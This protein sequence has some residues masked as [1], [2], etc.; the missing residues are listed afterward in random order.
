MAR[1]TRTPT[2]G[3]GFRRRG[4]RGGTTSTPLDDSGRSRYKGVGPLVLEYHAVS[5]T[6]DSDLAVTPAQLRRHL[7]YLLERGYSG[8]TF[9]QAAT[10]AST[11]RL[12]AVTFDDAH[13]SVLELAYPIL[14]S[15]GVPGT[16]FVV[17]DYA[18]DGRLLRWARSREWREAAYDPELRGM[19]WSHLRQLADAGWEVGSHTK[20]H[21]R[22]T[23]LADDDLEREL[24]E[25]REACERALRRRC[26]SLAYPFGN[27]DARVVRMTAQAGYTVAA[28]E[29]PAPPALLMW[30][31]VGI[32]R[33]DSMLRFRLKVSPT[34][35]RIWTALVR[36][37]GHATHGAIRITPETRFAEMLARR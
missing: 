37:R 23:Q 10:G 21:P 26:S 13:L 27:T 12:V 15:L 32:Y 1:I 31:R 18:D 28:I 24:R 29:G 7:E 20:T 6:W 3:N 36:F 5:E 30:P 35:R 19:T 4:K 25:S 17:T 22:L 8:C 2:G 34:I 11:D 33:P 14:T 16:V 9:T